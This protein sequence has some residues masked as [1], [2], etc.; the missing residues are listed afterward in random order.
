MQEY[1]K[2]LSAKLFKLLKKA[3][4][5]TSVKRIQ[6]IYYRVKYGFTPKEIGEMIG[7][8][9]NYVEQIQARFWREGEQLF[10][11][12]EKGGRHNENLSLEEE[13]QLLDEF[14]E[15]SKEGNIIEISRIHE[16]YTKIVKEKEGKQP[17]KSTT[18]R[19]LNRHE[20][21]KITPRPKHS[22]NNEEKMENFKK[23]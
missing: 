13:S 20:W 18:Y 17:A 23:R 2:G 22:K 6:C 16:A 19:M 10:I 14:K 11:V 3:N 15:K 5:T 8:N 21:R 7:Y 12:K 9:T 1:E 4:E